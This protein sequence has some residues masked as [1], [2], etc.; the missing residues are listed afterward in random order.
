MRNKNTPDLNALAMFVKVAEEQSFSKAARKLG[1]P[2][3]TLSRKISEL[4]QALEARLLERSTRKLR[5]TESGQELCGYCRAGLQAFEEGTLRLQDRQAECAGTLRISAPP[6]L[7]AVLIAPLVCAYQKEHPKVKI[8]V[9]FTERYV[10]FIEEGIDLV[11]RVGELR[12]S[13][14]IARSLLHYHHLIVSS[15]EYLSQSKRIKTPTDLTDH[16]VIAFG[17]WHEPVIWRLSQ[18]DQRTKITVEPSLVLNDYNGILYA[19]EHA[20]GIA[21]IPSLICQTAINEG[22]LTQVLPRWQLSKTKLSIVYPS[23]LNATRVQKSFV[24]FCFKYVR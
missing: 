11:F 21:E 24:A 23:H 20:F 13:N 14:L 5:L 4:E 15:R 17:A 16:K 6:N 22:K 1:V 3:S 18:H 9:L 7:A 2:I 10:D 19:V 8:K 12:D